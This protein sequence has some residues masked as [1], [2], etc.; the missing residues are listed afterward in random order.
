ML[1]LNWDLRKARLWLDELP[2]WSY[3]SVEVV[4]CGQKAGDGIISSQRCMAVELFIPIGG[5]TH[6]GGMAIIFTPDQRNDLFVQ[7]PISPN[8]GVIFEESLARKIDQSY[9]GF[10]REYVTGIVEGLM[11][12][13]HT[14]LLGSGTLRLV[15]A[16]HGR[17]GSSNWLFRTLGSIGVRLLTLRTIAIPESELIQILQAEIKWIKQ[18]TQDL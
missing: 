10:P 18:T 15:G 16:V 6:Y 9:I 14:S 13:E 8:D 3:E 12:H 5:R 2:E 1:V 7:I 4:E 11:Q 17:M